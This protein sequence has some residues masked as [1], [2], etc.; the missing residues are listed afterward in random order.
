VILPDWMIEDAIRKG[1]LEIKYE[2]G[3]PVVLS[4]TDLL[5]PHSVDLTLGPS[6][7]VFKPRE[8]SVMYAPHED[9]TVT[10]TS[11][12]FGSIFTPTEGL[13]DEYTVRNGYLLRQGEFLLAST[14]EIVNL[15]GGRI[16]GIVKGKS[17]IA[18]RGLQVEGAGLVD[19]NF[20]GQITLEIAN[21]S[22]APFQLSAG[23]KM[24]Q[25]VFYLCAGEPR[26]KYGDEGLNSHYQGQMGPT[27]AR[28]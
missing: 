23:M 3:D 14:R 15:K 20:N 10:G 21:L 28:S 5:Q 9:V 19:T 7:I 8:A 25:I 2:N 27:R 11:V 16:A 6:M 24:C 12:R 26:R 1:D 4:D 18:R 22:P 17:T 13:H